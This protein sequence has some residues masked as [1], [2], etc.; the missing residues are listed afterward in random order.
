M[1]QC[2]TNTSYP[3]R[4]QPTHIVNFSMAVVLNEFW[5]GMRYSSREVMQYIRGEAN[6]MKSQS[7]KKSFIIVYNFL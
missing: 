5:S 2:G 3:H 4:A 6:S 7:L 1:I